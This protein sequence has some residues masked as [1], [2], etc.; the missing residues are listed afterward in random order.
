M[1]ALIALEMNSFS[2]ELM[3]TREQFYCRIGFENNLPFTKVQRQ[4]LRAI[5]RP[6]A[7]TSTKYAMYT[8]MLRHLL[9]QE[10]RLICKERL[11]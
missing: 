10:S 2:V 11:G 7:E 4:H 1:D 6:Q 3:T 8:T 9:V 5:E